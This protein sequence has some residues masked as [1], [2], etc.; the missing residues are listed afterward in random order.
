MTQTQMEA[1]RKQNDMKNIKFK[2]MNVRNNSRQWKQKPSAGETLA[3]Q[4]T[5]LNRHGVIN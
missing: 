5:G 3:N 4:Q 1:D 2:N